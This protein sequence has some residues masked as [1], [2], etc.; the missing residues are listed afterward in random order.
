MGDA[1]VIFHHWPGGGDTLSLAE[2]AECLHISPH[3][4]RSHLRNLFQ[5]TETTLQSALVSLILRMQSPLAE[6]K[7]R[8]LPSEG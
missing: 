7:G 3:T 4:V 1:A 2:M 5:K 6:S 8:G